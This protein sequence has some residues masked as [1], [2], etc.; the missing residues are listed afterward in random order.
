MFIQIPNNSQTHSPVK[1][2]WAA[3]AWADVSDWELDSFLPTW[4]YMSHSPKRTRFW[5]TLFES[6]N[7]LEGE[8]QA[9]SQQGERDWV[10]TLDCIKRWTESSWSHP[11][12]SE[13]TL[14]SL[15]IGFT[16]SGISSFRSVM[17]LESSISG[18]VGVNDWS[19]STAFVPKPAHRL[20][21]QLQLAT[22][23]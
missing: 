21:S 6:L 22:K 4:V 2:D 3:P 1:Q 8:C 17:N 13:Y 18:C 7:H 23:H 19:V 5:A 14:G 10:E 12:V 16:V 11:L 20:V 15:A 9:A